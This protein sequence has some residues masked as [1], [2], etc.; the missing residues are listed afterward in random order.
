VFR[1][2]TKFS[3]SLRYFAGTP[4]SHPTKFSASLR[5]FAGTPTSR[6][7]R[8]ALAA[9]AA[10][11]CALALG[12]T[13]VAPASAD[14]GDDKRAVDQQVKD[15]KGALQEMSTDVANA[16]TALQSTQ[17]QVPAAQAALTQA[18]D[19]ERAANQHN[20]EVAAQLA[21][22]QANEQRALEAEATNQAKLEQ[23][24]ATLD[25]FAADLF[26]G[27]GGGSQMS[28]ALGA[29]SADDFATRVVLADQVGSLTDNALKEL[30]NARA[31]ASAQE[32]YLK[33]VEAE[34]AQLKREAEDALAQ[35]KAAREAAATAKANL[36]ALLAQQAAYAAQVEAKKADEEKRLAAA[37]AEQA[38]L[39]AVLEAQARAAA[40]A[41]A[42]RAAAA[43]AAGRAYTPVTGGTGFL[44]RAANGPIT[45]PFGLR[46][47]PIL[48]VWKLHSG[49]DFAVPCG[50]PVY[51][52]ADGTVISAGYG[53][54]NGNRIVID[55]GIVS[56]VDLASTYNHLT[57]FVVRSG[58]VK[59]GQLI[60]YSGTTGYS[61]GCHLH[62]ETLE[63]GQF[64]NPMKWL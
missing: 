56:G 29:T 51:A 16:Y 14:T 38:R 12:A 49:T 10:A 43:R 35:A 26:Q 61:T 57:S 23:T 4:T 2:P 9:G 52:A 31:E 27:G 22:A 28:V 24:Q 19:T 50:T 58:K 44:S 39:Q 37:E 3:A 40:A 59:R 18:E 17:A 63:N 53:G 54:G 30:E 45:S 48:H 55:H 13:Q 41:E 46:Y 1:H 47:H 15:I 42:A 21:V 60:A 6:L 64:V 25:N 36:D 11:A 32:A 34:V 62:F 5:Y 33:A 7:R 20:D 8:R